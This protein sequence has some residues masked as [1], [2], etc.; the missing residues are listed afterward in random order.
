MVVVMVVVV[1]VVAPSVF[2]VVFVVVVVVVQKSH[3]LLSQLSNLQSESSTNMTRSD[4]KSEIYTICE[5][6]HNF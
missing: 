2:V 5:A 4:V 3:E 6:T 1:V